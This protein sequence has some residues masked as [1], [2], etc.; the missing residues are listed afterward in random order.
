[1]T[2]EQ[3]A[4]R[5][6][7][8]RYIGERYGRDKGALMM[9]IASLESNFQPDATNKRSTASGLMQITS[10]HWA[11]LSEQVRRRV[12]S[13][14]LSVGDLPA[15]MTMSNIG[16]F[17]THKF[18]EISSAFMTAVNID[19]LGD[20]YVRKANKQR[21]A[22]GL[23]KVESME[24]L[25]GGNYALEAFM[26]AG[27]HKDGWG[28][29]H[30]GDLKGTG[31]GAA[32]KGGQIDID[33]LFDA[34]ATAKAAN[35]DYDGD[36][37]GHGLTYAMY[38]SDNVSETAGGPKL[39]LTPQQIKQ[40]L[41]LKAG[42]VSLRNK[43]VAPWIDRAQQID[44]GF[45]PNDESLE[46]WLPRLDLADPA[47]LA[48]ANDIQTTD[49]VAELQD[50]AFART[51]A[52]QQVAQ[53][54]QRQVSED[55][56]VAA[57]AQARMGNRV[58]RAAEDALG[59]SLEFLIPPAEAAPINTGVGGDLPAPPSGAPTI[60]TPGANSMFGSGGRFE[61][62]QPGE[63]SRPAADPNA[64]GMPSP[65]G[66]PATAAA[67]GA[68]A[69]FLPGGRFAQEMPTQ[70]PA[71]PDQLQFPQSPTLPVGEQAGPIDLSG[72]ALG[73]I[74]DFGTD[75]SVIDAY[76]QN[77]NSR[78]FA[79]YALGLEQQVDDFNTLQRMDSAA[80]VDDVGA[81]AS[82]LQAEQQQDLALSFTPNVA[83]P[84]T[85][86]MAFAQPNLADFAVPTN[87]SAN[88][89]NVT[90]SAG[91]L[92]DAVDVSRVQPIEYEMAAA[93]EILAQDEFGNANDF[94]NRARGTNLEE[95][96]DN[97]ALQTAQIGLDAIN[98]GDLTFQNFPEIQALS[99]KQGNLVNGMAQYLVNRSRGN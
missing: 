99:S 57:R 30:S 63:S 17:D 27:G 22:M 93:R 49:P 39:Q 84:Q 11:T 5:N 7:L 74:M 70:L 34:Y 58:A 88:L 87:P 1:M 98:R 44:P 72:G 47:A 78:G 94:I 25:T 85:Q 86:P 73:S 83:L 37:L 32:I 79:D 75:Q 71:G 80:L 67:P 45:E 55:P 62:R 66:D 35:T 97:F 13:G 4:A 96:A 38:A 76:T 54:E 16:D 3:I 64:A 26:I 65:P 23:P 8:R 51:R 10:G 40:G 31:F 82:Q 46:Q 43:I 95:Q 53:P 41:S 2:P 91:M 28:V 42:N 20:Q 19:F 6:A 18:D 12:A 52:P 15:G 90:P 29:H 9:N 36:G 69:M 60:N 21:S 68:N 48:G 92:Q 59:S 81:R 33:A 24:E 89:G 61:Q 56:L 77:Q 50:E 14:Q